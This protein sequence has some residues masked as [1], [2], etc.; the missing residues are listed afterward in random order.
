MNQKQQERLYQLLGENVRRHRNQ[1]GFTQ[2]QL[3]ER[4]T[5]TRTSIVNIEQ[6]R[7][8]PPLHLLFQIAKALKVPVQVLIPEETEFV[9]DT[10]LDEATLKDVSDKD[11][12]KLTAFLTDHL[13]MPS[14]H[15]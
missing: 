15:D 7:Q 6:G 14:S 10:V 3:A 8:H 5:L 9:I 2:E 12:S 1:R 4:V 11:K 13:K